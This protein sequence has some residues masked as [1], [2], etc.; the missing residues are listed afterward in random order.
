LGMEQSSAEIDAHLDGCAECRS[1]F[2]EIR[3]NSAVLREFSEEPMPRVDIRR[4]EVWPWAMAAAAML[5]IA[6]GLWK[7]RPAVHVSP[8]A[9]V[10]IARVE[11]PEPLRVQS[12]AP[13][14]VRRHPAIVRQGIVKQGIV[15]SAAVEPLKVKMFTSDPDVVI[16]W[17]VEAKEGQE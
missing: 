14:L 5:V 11:R 13:P 2:E 17:I 7:A 10:A 12:P 6:I 9:Q 3:A 16:Y 15:K 1:I 4:R 8:P